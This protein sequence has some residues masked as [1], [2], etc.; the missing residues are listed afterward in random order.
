MPIWPICLSRR[1]NVSPRPTATSRYSLKG[2]TLP[3][4][5][6]MGGGRS[7]RTGAVISPGLA[8]LV[9]PGDEIVAAIQ[10]LTGWSMNWFYLLET[11]AMVPLFIVFAFGPWS[12]RG[13]VFAAVM[14]FAVVMGISFWI[15]SGITVAVTRQRQ[16][17]CFRVP[18]PMFAKG[19]LVARAPVEVLDLAVVRR[20]WPFDQVRYGGPSPDGRPLRFSVPARYRTATNQI[21]EAARGSAI[22]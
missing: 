20:G 12:A 13:T 14:A 10:G 1:M 8:R 15:R 3:N 9:D 17:L 6:S 21:I 2:R 16:V 7:D 19:A 11:V 4:V 22:S 5:V 18:R